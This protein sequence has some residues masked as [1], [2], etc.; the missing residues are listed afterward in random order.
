MIRSMTAFARA[1]AET[2]WGG[3]AWELRSVNHRYLDIFLRLP[4]DFRRL[5]NDVRA[6]INA[7]LSRGKV[8][9]ALTFKA[10]PGEGGLQVDHRLLDALVAA[11][12]TVRARLPHAAPTSPAELLRWPGLV[13]TA[14]PDLD[15]LHCRALA[16]LDQ[17]LDEMVATRE[18]EGERLAGFIRQRLDELEG[19]VETVRRRR[20]QVLEAQRRRLRERLQ[21]L[22]AEVD[23]GR[24]EQEMALLIQRLDVD[25]ELDRLRS[26]IEEVRR[27]LHSDQPV[28]RRLDF[29]MQELNREANTLAS[30]SA[31]A[32]TTR[33]AVEMK[34]LIEQM[35]EQVQN[36]E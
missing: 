18:R 21:T 15:Q 14:V 22:A 10:E 9:A 27:Q 33:A 19:L 13:E 7:R 16:L 1:E 4:E 26:H 23:E 29:L 17:A 3:L 28:G 11:L 32:E 6:H 12:E 2:P 8:E 30:K 34:V 20:P 25:E 5:E 36:I 24:L 31:D 35:R